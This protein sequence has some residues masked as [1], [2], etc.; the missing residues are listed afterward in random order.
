MS[1]VLQGFL[2][3]ALVGVV[4]ALFK[5]VPPAPATWA[6]VA[7]IVGIVSGWWVVNRL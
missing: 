7:A 4:F 2:L 3:G 5:L 1:A 6:G